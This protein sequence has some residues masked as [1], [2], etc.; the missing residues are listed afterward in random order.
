MCG[1]AV[2]K[3]GQWQR[4]RGAIMIDDFVASAEKYVVKRLAPP[5]FLKLPFTRVEG[6]DTGAG[7]K[8]EWFD[9]HDFYDRPDKG[10]ANAISWAKRLRFRGCAGPLQGRCSNILEIDAPSE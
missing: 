2:H 5:P 3:N 4:L 8:I 10:K 6:T 1:R 7:W 9:R